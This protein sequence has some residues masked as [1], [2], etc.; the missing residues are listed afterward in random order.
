MNSSRIVAVSFG[1]VWVG[2]VVLGLGMLL[3]FD[4]TPGVQGGTPARWPEATALLRK[5]GLPTLVMAAH[6]QCSCTRA[7]LAELSRIMATLAGR[8]DAHVVVLSPR[9][10]P[11]SWVENVLWRTAE[12]IPGVTVV[13]D[14]GGR[15]ADRFGLETSGQTLLYDSGG[16]LRFAGGVTSMRGHEGDN[17][18]RSA[19]VALVTGGTPAIDRTL[20]F[21]CALHAET[22]GRE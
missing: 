22:G 18:G 2:G 5:P 3:V 17:A 21:G 11:R 13:A 8:L 20:V 1:A 4:T 19:I 14:A 6:P 10:V 16:I 15:E 9:D 12:E 7:S